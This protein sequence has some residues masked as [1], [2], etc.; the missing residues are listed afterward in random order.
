MQI[1]PKFAKISDRYGGVGLVI[2]GVPAEGA[3]LPTKGETLKADD[4]AVSV[5][6]AYEGYSFEAGLRPRDTILS[7]G[8]QRPSSKAASSDGVLDSARSLLRGA[9]VGVN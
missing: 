9:R 3:T 8:G 7:I 4:I 2:S 5:V 6:D 1:K